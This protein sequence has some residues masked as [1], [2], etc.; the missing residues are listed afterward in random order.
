ME[1]EERA[2]KAGG[3]AAVDAYIAAQA[4][5][6]HPILEKMRAIIRSAAP[7]AEEVISYGI[8]AYKQKGMVVAF[9]AAKKHV[10]LYAMSPAVL[11]GL[12]SELSGYDTS[13]GTVRFPLQK[14]LDEKL[15]RRIVALRLA[16]N[17]AKRGK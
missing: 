17:E 12:Q 2:S 6:I 16:E 8:P 1:K 4:P 9:G 11:E 7:Q 15:I 3:T 10:G 13:K 14:P 5:D